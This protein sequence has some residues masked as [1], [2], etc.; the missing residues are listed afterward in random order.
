M[1]K[2]SHKI[3]FA[4][5]LALIL[6][7]CGGTNNE[8]S[9]SINVTM[10]DFS[11]SPNVF[12]VPAGQQISFR[13]QNNGAVAHSFIIMRAGHEVKDHFTSA[14]QPNVYWEQAEVDPGQSAQTS[15]TAPTQPGTYQIVCG[16]G[17]H[18]EAGMVAKLIVVAA[19]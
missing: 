9:T 12:T 3:A 5:A 11:Y 15:F 19:Q 7:A 6:S 16:N 18:F 2:Y 13:A 10:T 4:T 17:G 14:D 8:P 1:Q